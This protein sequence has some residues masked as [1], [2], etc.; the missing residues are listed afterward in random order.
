MWRISVLF[1]LCLCTSVR[2]RVGFSDVDKKQYESGKTQ[3]ELLQTQAQMPEYGKCWTNTLTSLQEGC[4]HLTDETQTRL[5]LAYLNCF[6]QVQG[7]DS[8]QCDEGMS[9]RECLLDIT[10]ADRPSL[11]TFFTHTQN[12]CYFLQSQ[13]WHE[14]T[15]NTIKRLSRA[16]DE[17]A[18]NL[19]ATTVLQRE[20]L[21][22][23]EVIMQQSTNLS[24]II[25][26]SSE[27]LHAIISDFHKMTNDQRILINDIFD[28]I[29]HLQRTMLGEFSGFYSVVYYTLSIMLSYLLTSTP[30]TAPARFWMFG[31]M[32]LNIII[33]RF[34]I[35]M[36][37]SGYTEETNTEEAAYAWHIFCRRVSGFL[38][39]VV[40]VIHAIRYQDFNVLN[41]QLLM[42]IKADLRHLRS[43]DLRHRLDE[44]DHTLE[45][46]TPGPMT[47]ASS[48][49][50]HT[51]AAADSTEGYESDSAWSSSSDLSDLDKSSYC[52]DV[53]YR[54][55]PTDTYRGDNSTASYSYSESSHIDEDEVEF[56]R[57][58]TPI[59]EGNLQRI[60]TWSK[61]GYYTTASGD[62]KFQTPSSTSGVY[63]TTHSKYHLRQ[64]TLTQLM[65]P[66]LREESPKTFRRKIKNLEQ[67]A[68][69]NSA[70]LR[71]TL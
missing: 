39:I 7:R 43:R 35:T 41:Y 19:A 4:K 28:K 15:Q 59:R 55:S 66:A 70:A 58:S 20:A 68:M 30:R 23:Q 64:R 33:E 51:S 2:C 9:T 6:L 32:T 47:I 22:N 69:E 17:V 27:N 53:S 57:N 38:A 71:D 10:E 29:V 36:F 54:P 11:T 26:S 60:K 1:I 45:S 61:T 12:I 46:P 34:I 18:E 49:Q 67:V 14:K 48:H 16:S 56:L 65:N 42:D 31:I 3:Y 37:I 5:A 21:R 52:T 24:L 40:L 25:N 50:S 13:V 8:Y 63:K 44:I 62:D